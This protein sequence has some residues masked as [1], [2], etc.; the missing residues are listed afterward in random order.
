[1]RMNESLFTTV[2]N[3]KTFQE[4][5][6]K[7]IDILAKHLEEV[8]QGMG[9]AIPFNNADDEYEFWK[10]YTFKSPEDF[11]QKLCDRSVRVH[12]KKYMGHQVSAP[13]PLATLVALTSAF[14]NNGSAVFEM[15]IANNA[16]ERLLTELLCKKIGFNSKSGGVLTSGGSLANLTALLTAKAHY[17]KQHPTAKRLGIMVG[18]QAHYSI[19]RT[20]RIMGLENEA[21][22][23]I[24]TSNDFTV[25][26]KEINRVYQNASEKGIAI[27]AFVGNA[28][29]TATGKI[30]DLKFIG[31][32]CK[33]HNL[34]FHIDAAHGGAAI[35]S[36]KYTKG[37]EGIEKADSIIIYGHKMMMMPA[38]TTAVLYKNGSNAYHTFK[39]KADYLLSATEEE[40]WSNFG[41]RTFE[42]T[43]NMMAIEWYVMLNVYG[44]KLFD[45]FVT[46]TYDNC[47]MLANKINKHPNLELAVYPDTNILCFRYFDQHKT[48]EELNQINSSLRQELLEE[49]EFYILKTILNNKTYI[50]LNSMNPFTE[51][52]DYDLILEKIIKKGVAIV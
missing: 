17:L 2:Y 19:E 7:I 32:Y 37:L 44:E 23:L 41:K 27:F 33:Q 35:F 39:Q 13:A 6:V 47:R 12:H 49:G 3:S 9:Q 4:Q 11:I 46:L 30:D 48:D 43:K 29:S 28:P 21:L 10:N 42:C 16:I 52:S 18:D 1:M 34:W 14:L 38:L 50:R 22:V 8:T 45:Q 31:N 15:G 51:E 24:P 40:D 36:K 25:A 5:G 26:T 20:A